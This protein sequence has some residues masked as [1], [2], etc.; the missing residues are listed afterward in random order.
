MNVTPSEHDSYQHNNH[1]FFTNCHFLR[2]EARWSNV[3]ENE[4]LNTPELPFS[5]G[6]GLAVFFKGNASGCNVAISACKFKDNRASWGGGLQVLME[7]NTE[8]N[9]VILEGTIFLRN[10]ADLSAG[11]ARMGST[12]LKHKQL[13]LNRFNISNC[14]FVQNEAL[15]GGGASIFG[16]KIASTKYSKHVVTQFHFRQST[17]QHNKAN[18][19]AAMGLYLYNYNKYNF[20]P[21]VPYCVCFDSDTV[22]EFNHVNLQHGYLKMGQGNVY[23]FEVPLI[24]KSTAKFW[25]NSKSAL[26]LD[27]S[28]LEVHD[29]LEFI[30]NT[31]FRGGAIAMY[32]RSRIIFHKNAKL[33]FEANSCDDKGGAMY[34]QAPGP[35]LVSF[36]ATG[37]NIYTCF[38]AYSDSS[39]HYDKWNATVIFK[40]NRAPRDASGKSVYVT[41]LKGCW[42]VGENR[43][44]N[45]VLRWTFVKFDN[46][47]ENFTNFSGEVA[48][49]PIAIEYVKTDWRV[50]PGESFNAIVRLYDEVKNLVPGIIDIVI[51]PSSVHLKPLSALFL[52]TG[53]ITNISLH[54]IEGSKF[55]VQLNCNGNQLL[56]TVIEDLELKNCYAG[57][58]FSTE[59]LT[60]ECMDS[61]KDEQA[62]GVSHCDPDGKSLYV[63]RGY[64]AGKVNG[65]FST[66]VCPD[67][68]CK[69]RDSS[70]DDYLYNEN[71]VCEQHRKQSSILCGQGD[72]DYSVTVGSEKCEKE[73]TNWYLL[74][75]I[76]FALV[77]LL[78]VMVIMLIDL[79]VFTGPGLKRLAVLLPS[80]EIL[81]T[82][83]IFI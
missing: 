14:S 2:N 9:S 70:D 64:W 40:D 66:Y 72:V 77:L 80:H 73:C 21:Q 22:F 23:S 79:D 67:G 76:P 31:G 53:K 52:T 81:S 62:R 45:S 1:Y 17:W 33:T 29:Q 51:N 74:L 13:I 60:C 18:V 6:G 41:T 58:R 82:K 3:S 61:V 47:P 43:T 20:G 48:T 4:D 15:W 32:G 7:D 49:D 78:I 46:L 35:P 42:Q 16:R 68:Y 19:G 38:F 8:N 57:F 65:T 71:H 26:V 25:H 37:N 39:M 24:F 12:P 54:G 56:S 5:R 55:Y 11:G 50:A 27:G 28:T 75:L 44:N 63:K 34:I 10:K 59:K 83:W 30:N 69:S 36:N